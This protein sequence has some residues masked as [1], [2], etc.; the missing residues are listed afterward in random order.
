MV[1]LPLLT[2]IPIQQE[3]YCQGDTVEYWGL[4][5]RVPVRDD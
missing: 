3:N 5:L 2:F 1:P 4:A